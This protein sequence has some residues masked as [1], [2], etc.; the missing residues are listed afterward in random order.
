MPHS[1]TTIIWTPT[2]ELYVVRCGSKNR[3]Q[4]D[5]VCLEEEIGLRAQNYVNYSKLNGQHNWGDLYVHLMSTR[6][7]L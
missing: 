6:I 5:I 1:R 3:H 4:K 2:F 7:S